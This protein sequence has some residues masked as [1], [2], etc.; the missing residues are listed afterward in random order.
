MSHD[1]PLG[2]SELAAQHLWDW[3]TERERFSMRE[4]YEQIDS[5]RVPERIRR[6]VAYTLIYRAK[7]AGLF[8]ESGSGEGGEQVFARPAS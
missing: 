6:N 3:L 5:A 8:V 2:I 7:K 4:L 1:H